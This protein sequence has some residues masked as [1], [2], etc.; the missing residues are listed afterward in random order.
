[1]RLRFSD[2]ER[3]RFFTELQ[4]KGIG[5]GQIA[6]ATGVSIRT[7]SDWKRGKYTIPTQ[8]FN[9]IVESAAINPASIKADILGSWWNNAAAGKKGS[10]IRTIRHGSFGT[11][12][13]RSRGGNNSYAKRKDMAG[14]IF[15]RNKILHP[16]RNELFAEFI[17]IMIGDGNMTKYQASISLSSLVDVE[18]SCYVVNLVEKLFGISPRVTKALS[19]NCLVI[20]VSSI[21]LVEFLNQNGVLIGDKIRQKLDIPSWILRDRECALACVRGIFDTDGCVFQERH[22]INGK[23]Y[24][25]PRLSLVSASSALRSSVYEVLSDLEFSPKIRNNRSVN[26]ERFSDIATYFKVVGTS[27][28][29]HLSRWTLFGEVA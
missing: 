14:D 10:A 22:N 16:T 21:E 8:H 26:L 5:L 4:Q 29:K 12:E 13:G 3:V 27:N 6:S 11:P 20:V 23:S 15:A 17:G 24:A 25:Y 28:S 1:M 2:E 19:S 18:Y 9:K 7:V